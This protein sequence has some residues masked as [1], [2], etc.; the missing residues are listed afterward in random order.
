M[1][2]LKG[3]IQTPV[4]R[5][6]MIKGAHLIGHEALHLELSSE[7]I[8]RTS[9]ALLGAVTMI[10]IILG[11]EA[12]GAQ[13]TPLWWA[14]AIGVGLG[15]NSTHIGA[16]ANLIAVTEAAQSGIEGARITPLTWMR[17]G[18]PTTLL[19]LLVASAIYATFFDFFAG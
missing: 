8:H 16:T 18:I 3:L 12:S 14:L 4:A 11:L 2:L 19:G 5:P 17:I 1:G 7:I 9:A 10:P 13:I 15:G 6:G